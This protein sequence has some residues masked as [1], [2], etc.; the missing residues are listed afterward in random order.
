MDS[1]GGLDCLIGMFRYL[2]TSYIKFDCNE[3][4]ETNLTKY[5]KFNSNYYKAPGT[6]EAFRNAY[7]SANY[8]SIEECIEAL[9]SKITYTYA[10][11]TSFGGKIYSNNT[12]VILTNGVEVTSNYEINNCGRQLSSNE[13]IVVM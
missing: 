7:Y 5:I 2:D 13:T 4:E 12:S 8:N 3:L 10:S 6:T 9:K 11:D 1:G